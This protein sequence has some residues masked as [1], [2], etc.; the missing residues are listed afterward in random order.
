[1]NSL[2]VEDSLTKNATPS[3]LDDRSQKKVHLREEAV[4]DLG[5]MPRVVMHNNPS[6]MDV[7]LK[8]TKDTL[9]LE[10]DLFSDEDMAFEHADTTGGEV[11]NDDQSED[12]EEDF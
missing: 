11:E 4:A 2:V 9:L 1:M 6:F 10:G 7:L 8:S 12:D 5:T 3:I